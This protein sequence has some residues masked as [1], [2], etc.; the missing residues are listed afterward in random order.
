MPSPKELAKALARQ[1]SVTQQPRN[2]FLGAIADAAGYVSDQAD[3]YVV[4]ERDPLFGGMR[5]GDL[6]PL[7]N[8]NRLLDDLS[9][10]GR[11]TTGR[12]QT[13]TLRPEVVDTVAL[14]GAMM[15]AAKS[16]SKAA[17]MK[18]A[19]HI[20]D[21]TGF[22]RLMPDPRMRMFAGE[23]AKTADK[24][25]L[26]VA[27][28]MK[29]AGVPDEQIHAKT[30]WTFAFADGKPR[31]EIDDS[32][33]TIRGV[34]TVE[35]VAGRQGA[36]VGDVM[37]HPS[38]YDEYQ[39]TRGIPLEFKGKEGGAYGT[40]MFGNE[41][42]MLGKNLS[43]NKSGKST[44]LHELQHSIQ[45]QE[46]FATGGSPDMFIKHDKSLLSKENEKYASAMKDLIRTYKESGKSAS[47][48]MNSPQ[49]K[50]LGESLNKL[51]EAIKYPY[52]SYRRLAGEAEARLTQ[53]RMNMNPAERA[54]SYPPS[55]FDVPV[56]DQIVRYGDN[57][58]QMATTWHGSPHTFPPTAN[59]P[60]GEFD[61]MKVGT[62]E[63]AQAYGVGAGY[64][65]EA[66]KL[67]EGYAED[68]TKMRV[69]A[70]QSQLNKY[71]GSVDDAIGAARKEIDRLKSLN[72]TPETGAAKRDSLIA[73]QG[74]KL[75][76]LMAYKNQ[77]SMNKG[78][79]YKVDLPDEHVAKM[80]DWDKPMNRQHPNVQRAFN[81]QAAEMPSFTVSETG[82]PNPQYKYSAGGFPAAPTP[83]AALKAASDSVNSSEWMTGVSGEKAYRA[84]AE[85]IGA[86]AAS[87]KLA[88]SGIPGIRYLDAASRDAAGKGTSNFVVFDPKHMNIL[89]RNDVGGAMI[90]RPKTEFEILHDTAQRNAALPVEQGGLGLPAN[91]TYIDR[92]NAPGMWPTDVYHGSN[93]DIKEF[94]PS[95]AG[96]SSATKTGKSKFIWATSSPKNANN[97]VDS[98]PE[99]IKQDKAHVFSEYGDAGRLEGKALQDLQDNLRVQSGGVIYPLRIRTEGA[100]IK[101]GKGRVTT[102]KDFAR[103]LVKNPDYESG[104]VN[105]TRDVSPD[106]ESF[107]HYLTSNPANIRS[108]FA[109]FDPFR[110]HEADIL[111]GVG[112]GGMLDPQAIAEA[113]RQQDRK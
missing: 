6:L 71:G 22:A 20:Q 80:L 104:I 65:A 37:W 32:P 48:A 12:G 55:M 70:A 111:A 61:P 31:F 30:K 85:K 2:R 50:I 91:N 42:I 69:Q 79:L 94:N 19:E 83:E 106:S 52:E 86:T 58:P 51:Q 5:G 95:L 72:L 112:V 66:K 113:L 109:A 10:G 78:N 63:G 53:S 77:G 23:G 103:Q 28:D 7:R 26:K 74:E 1:D 16:L 18:A 24:G 62:G 17:A 97:Y 35:E 57:G 21:R 25:A 3:R 49:G 14:G 88:Q 27:K 54:A 76:E 89:E 44:L 96:T 99:I 64:L 67:A 100:L 13:T 110:R 11:I 41:G 8:V 108:R 92:A 105:N 56:K 29:A 84:M 98:A 33:A 15:P 43:G 68:L 47:D 60:L 87:K 40:D 59:N 82:H 46:G 75:T 102:N 36:N 45:R 9:H 73:G 107:S 4:P 81:Y 90:Q 93:V 34:G 38:L 39:N 101:D